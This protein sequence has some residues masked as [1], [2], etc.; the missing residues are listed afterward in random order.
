MQGLAVQLKPPAWFVVG[1]GDVAAIGQGLALEH[2][3]EV[4]LDLLGL[5]VDP[6]KSERH[7]YNGYT[8]YVV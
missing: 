6:E 1:Q 4:G 5:G 8:W 2:G 3:P 7:G